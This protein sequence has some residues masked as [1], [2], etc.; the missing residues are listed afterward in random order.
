[1]APGNGGVSPDK[2]S[3]QQEVGVRPNI[4]R[5]GRRRPKDGAFLSPILSLVAPL[6]GGGDR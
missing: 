3:A 5:L 6:W 2:E 4:R 1:M